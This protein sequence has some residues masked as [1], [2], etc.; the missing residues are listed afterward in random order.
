MPRLLIAPDDLAAVER[1]AVAAFPAECC[2]LLL[3]R[4][5][6]DETVR[7]GW[8]E[9]CVNQAPDQRCRFTISP[10]ALMGAYRWARDRGEKVVGTYHS[11]PGGEAV[12]STTD[13]ES[14]WPGASYLIVGL[15][16]EGVRQRRSWR[17]D[18]DGF[19]EEELAVRL[20]EDVEDEGP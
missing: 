19:V 1:R 12:P 6:D 2:G 9:E 16:E 4:H 8:V 10:E 14:A 20:I 11:H 18:G 13:R 15:D 3:G 5:E 7:I 17:L